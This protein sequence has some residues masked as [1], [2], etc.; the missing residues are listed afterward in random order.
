MGMDPVMA[1]LA[2]RQPVGYDGELGPDPTSAV[3]DLISAAPLA[4][5]AGRMFK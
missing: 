5:L 3:M 2:D 4:D 1:L